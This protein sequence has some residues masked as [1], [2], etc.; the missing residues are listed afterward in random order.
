MGSFAGARGIHYGAVS[1][2]DVVAC[3]RLHW[4][5]QLEVSR[6]CYANLLR[7]STVLAVRAEAAW[8]LNDLQTANNW[9][10]EAMR[11][12]PEDVRTRVRWGDL[13]ADSHQAAE[14][15]EIY[16]ETL[17]RDESNAFAMLGAARV[18]VGS[19]DDAA[20]AFLKP[21][22]N[23][24]TSDDGARVGALLLSARIA[25]E[26]G[27]RNEA[28]DAL[29]D[30]AEI[31]ERNDWPPLEVYALHAA[32]DLL[33]DV[34]ESRWTTKSLDYNPYYGGIYEVPAHF[35][36]ITRRY[37]EA[38]DLYQKAVDVDP[39]LASAHEDLGPDVLRDLP[40]DQLRKHALTPT[41]LQSPLATDLLIRYGT[42]NWHV[43]N[44]GLCHTR[45]K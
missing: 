22:L 32:A 18:L 34:T 31:V 15:M 16:R 40:I 12:N 21:L 8:A 30:A 41:H 19:F 27:K 36:V 28:L 24:S 17:E 23:E 11:E 45:R 5:G 26:N 37:R 14:A 35:Y 33:N 43:S 38:I 25:L 1:D 2:A 3:D 42:C 29:E 6:N 13:Y 39:R 7:N 44:P 9:F 4:G 10:K 20:N